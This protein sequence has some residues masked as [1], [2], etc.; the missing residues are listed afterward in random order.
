[1]IEKPGGILSGTRAI[2]NDDRV[3]LQAVARIVLD[4]EKGTLAEQLEHRAFWIRRFLGCAPAAFD[5]TILPHRCRRE[6]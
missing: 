5:L 3:L 4:D 2:P 1:M 6:N